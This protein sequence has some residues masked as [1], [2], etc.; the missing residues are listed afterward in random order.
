MK[1]NIDYQEKFE[2]RHIAPNEQDTAKM[3][4]TIG[5]NSIDELISQTVPP[6]IRLK[7][8]LNLPAAKS[9]ADYLNDLK[10]TASKNKVFKSYIG[11]GY[12]DVI[13]PGV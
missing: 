2:Q 13:V 6:N 7:N 4:S 1:L 8:N 3:L 10:Q 5:V 12:H 9:E 11:Q